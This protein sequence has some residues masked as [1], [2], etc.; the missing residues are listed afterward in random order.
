LDLRSGELRKAGVRLGL[1]EQPLQI[2]AALLERPGDLVTRE[3]L[4]QRL[5]PDGTFVDFEHGLNAVVSRLRD[6]LGDS[7]DSPRFIETVPRRGYRFVTPIGKGVN[8]PE[9]RA[10]SRETLQPTAESGD[11]VSVARHGQRQYSRRLLGV[12]VVLA[13]AAAASPFVSR[14]WQTNRTAMRTRPV[15][16]LPGQE[17]HPSF[18]PDG[19]Q[20]AYVWDGERGDNEDIYITLIDA[21]IPLRLTSHPAADRNPAWSPDGRHI[22]FVR[23]TEGG[24]DVFVVP[25]LG[26]SERRIGSLARTHEWAAGPSWSPDGKLLAVSD[27]E[28]PEAALSIVLLS[29]ETMERRQLTSPPV[30]S[31]GDCAPAVSP[32]GQTVAFN[33]RGSAG[34]IYLV[35]MTG[36]E[37]KR[38]TVEHDS[39]CERIAWMPDGRALVFSSSGGAPESN[40]SSLWRVSASGG[41]PD[42]L[43]VGGDSAANP[44]IST[45]GNRLAY[46]QRVQDAN[47]WRIDVAS[48]A[49]GKQSPT[50]VIASTRHEAGPHV[51]PDG[52]RIAFHSDRSGSFE[53]WVCDAAGANLVQV[54]SFGGPMV[55]APRWSPR[56]REI[57]FDIVENG[58]S[59]I[60]VVNVEGLRPRRVTTEPSD[61]VVPSWS[62]DGRWI[63]FS[64]NRTGRSEVW[65]V[66]AAGGP[67]V[68]V[69]TRGGF[70]AF[71]SNDGQFLYYS[72]GVASAGLW[73]VPTSGGRAS[74]LLDFPTAGYW[75]YWALVPSGIY[76]VNTE[77]SQRPTLE[78]FS[79]ADQRVSIVAALDRRP[80][81]S[82]PGIAVSPDGRWIL[83]TQE[84]HRSSDIMLVEDV[85]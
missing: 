22:A 2:L 57:A 66:P 58:H 38:V 43:P 25:A 55:G 56:G 11:S 33:R 26:G 24:R 69:T 28:E 37:P 27:R 80:V 46:E 59:N 6:T 77:L 49:E 74:R 5:W 61:E 40:S 76:F 64:S 75:G 35:P 53:I 1:Q 3:E 85:R 34:G 19:T 68:Q 82:E 18:S 71:E 17:R 7:A 47:I 23:S 42:R 4:R 51:S 73:R 30:G 52:T 14:L 50:K 20:M 44:T 65:K 36:G 29:L 15:T 72:D 10:P 60:H 78:R 13:L 67:A 21:G 81:R 41:T 31:V 54:T 62:A 45:R 9:V 32:D 63:Y 79:F 83:Y 12:V 70:A 8:V 16:T 48:A 84:D 39:F